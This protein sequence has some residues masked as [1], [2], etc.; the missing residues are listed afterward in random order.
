[1]KTPSIILKSLLRQER[2]ASILVTEPLVPLRHLSVPK[3]ELFLKRI[4]WSRN[5]IF[6]SILYQKPEDVLNNQ[7]CE[8][9]SRGTEFCAH[10]LW[11]QL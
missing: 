10:M 11:F 8:S 1:M 2:T 7:L 4:T 9:V 3:K 6:F 5:N